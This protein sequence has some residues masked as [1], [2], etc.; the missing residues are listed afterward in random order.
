MWEMTRHLLALLLLAAACS[1][2]QAEVRSID[3][4]RSELQSSDPRARAAAGTALALSGSQAAPA[5][6]ELLTALDDESNLVRAAV[7]DALAEIG[8]PASA[9][10]PSLA[11]R[12]SAESDPDILHAIGRT[13][14]RFGSS[15]MSS[16]PV[17]VEA[18]QSGSP[19]GRR[20]ACGVLGSL[21]ADGDFVVHALVRS[22]VADSDGR[23]RSA[24]RSALK[25]LRVDLT[26]HVDDLVGFLSHESPDVREQAADRLGEMRPRPAEAVEP[27]V[28]ALFDDDALRVRQAAARALRNMGEAASPAVPRLLQAMTDGSRDQRESAA[29]VLG[30]VTLGDPADVSA[31][32]RASIHDRELSVRLAARGALVRMARTSP[33]IFDDFAEAAGSPGPV[34]R[35]SVLIDTLGRLGE[36]AAPAVPNLLIALRE[37]T[38]EVREQAARALGRIGAPASDA[39]LPL[40]RLA[41]WDRAQGVREAADRSIKSIRRSIERR[42]NEPVRDGDEDED[43]DVDADEAPEPEPSEE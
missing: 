24:A 12:L 41:A 34:E 14:I 32:V 22:M 37:G 8:A 5:V 31:L 20:I 17:I 21:G 7:V 29:A 4:W 19:A 1:V 40:R 11:R 3:F 43:E 13:L 15:S 35:R 2:A 30:S 25:R 38:A 10:A 33:E 27:L 16:I 26:A 23:V 28:T 9:A 18:L 42:A 39:L 6:P 36:A